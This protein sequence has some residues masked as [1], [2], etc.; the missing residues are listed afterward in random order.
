MKGGR[1][2][3]NETWIKLYRKLLVSPIFENEKALKVWIW[4]LLKATHIKRDQLVGKTIVNLQNGQLIFGRQKASEELKMSESSVYSYI[5]L[6]EKLNMIS[7][8]NNNKFSIITIEKW[9]DYQ[10]IKKQDNNKKTGI[11]QQNNTNKNVN[12]I[13]LSLLSKYKVENRKNFMEYIKKVNSLKN[14]NKWIELT[15]EEQMKLLSEI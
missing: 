1:Y 3:E 13:Y 15:E 5:R 7:I 4:C 9:E 6:L 14:D 8:N 10:I 12:N 11:K 2:L